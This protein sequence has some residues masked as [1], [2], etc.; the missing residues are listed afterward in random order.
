MTLLRSRH[1]KSELQ[2]TQFNQGKSKTL[3]A[4]T[5]G[6][7]LRDDISNLKPNE[8]RILENWLPTTG[9]VQMRPGKTHH[10]GG[11]GIGEVK[12]LAAYVGYSSS[13]MLAACNGAIYD[14]TNAT[15]SDGN[16]I[17]TKVLLHADGVD[18]STTITDSNAGGSSHTWTAAGNAQI[19]TAQSKFGGASMLFDGTGDYVSTPD[20]ADF[21]LGSSD[22]TVDFWFRC[23]DVSGADRYAFGQTDSSLTT[24]TRS[25]LG[26]RLSTD[27]MFAQVFVGT[28]TY[29]VY[30][31]TVFNSSTNT[32]WHH[33]ALVRTGDT[34]KLFIDGEQEG[35]SV[36]IVGSANDSSNEF[37]VGAFGEYAASRWLGWIE[38]FRVSV[39]VAR[40]TTTFTPP[41]ASYTSTILDNGYSNDRWQTALYADRLFFVNGADTPQ[42]YNGSTIA[43]IAWS[44]SGLTN[45]NLVNVA[46]VRNRLW[47]CESNQAWVWYA[48]V[49]QITAAS[50]L[51][52]F[53]LHQ[54]AGGGYCMAVASWSR[55]GGDG[56]DDLIVFIMSTGEL[57]IYQ[58]DPATS[59][60]LIGKFKGAPPIGRQCA[61]QVGGELVIITTQGLLP[62][63]T[64]IGGTVTAQDIAAIDP[65]GK[66]APGLAHDATLDRSN[67]GWHGVFHLGLVYVN[68]PQTTGTLSKQRVLNTRNGS[69]TTYTALNCAAMCSFEGELYFGTMDGNIMVHD[70]AT[71]DGN[72]V[73]AISS[74]AF[75]YPSRRQDTNLFTAAR[76]KIQCDGTVTGFIGVDVDFNSRVVNPAFADFSTGQGGGLWDVSAWDDTPWGSDADAIQRWYSINGCGKAVSVRMTMTAASNDLQWFATDILYKP[77]GIR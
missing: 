22:F 60:T 67:P 41:V 53:D 10:A 35:S 17:Y 7:N 56:A 52:K 45:T 9:L 29:A 5:G 32:G 39:G 26:G 47:F 64:A 72:D 54:I 2:K 33:Y 3:P 40:W 68:V 46:L 73:V 49:G 71:D 20:H 76:P 65:W 12:T 38:E 75:V 37:S 63:S 28:N 59:F 44:G 6:L 42:V 16:D 11:L 70:G 55:D 58:G 19:D 77:G 18:A 43:D 57:I 8:A 27:V 15:E 66:I 50:A 30:G 48:N 13:K 23:D 36:A 74:G 1:P 24:A 4:P 69:W 31:S 51:L 62:V 14:V 25:V 34:L 21:T 61:F